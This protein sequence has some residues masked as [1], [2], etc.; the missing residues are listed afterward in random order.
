MTY[1]S[2]KNNNLSKNPL[3]RESDIKD[4]IFNQIIKKKQIKQRLIV[5]I[6]TI[7]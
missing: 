4:E 5:I 1:A 7:I 6:E 3:K 2:N